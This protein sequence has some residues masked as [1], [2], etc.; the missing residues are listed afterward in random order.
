[1]DTN[2]NQPCDK[3]ITSDSLEAQMQGLIL[4]SSASI[5]T[6]STTV[7]ITSKGKSKKN[8]NPIIGTHKLVNEFNR[9]TIKLKRAERL[10]QHRQALQRSSQHDQ[11]TPLASLSGHYTTIVCE[12]GFFVVQKIR[13]NNAF[14]NV[15]GLLISCVAITY[16]LVNFASKLNL[17]TIFQVMDFLEEDIMEEK[18][19][20]KLKD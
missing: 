1:M 11:S 15:A 3:Q 13:P 8:K 7:A 16:F 12:P 10:E 19:L 9:E 20:P 6:S 2:Q 18:E 5:A 4:V 14:V 17:T